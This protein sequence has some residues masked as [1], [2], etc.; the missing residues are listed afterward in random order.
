MSMDRCVKCAGIFDTD[1]DPDCY[2]EKHNYTNTAHPVNPAIVERVEW[3]CVCEACREAGDN[4]IPRVKFLGVQI[5]PVTHEPLDIPEQDHFMKCSDCGGMIDRRDLGAVFG[6]EG[7][8][9]H[10]SEDQ[11]Q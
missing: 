1:A 8:L 5:D 6:H 9:P 10:P 7:P 3:E 2:V 11:I 4:P